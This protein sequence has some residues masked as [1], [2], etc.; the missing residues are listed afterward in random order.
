MLIP[1]SGKP[2][3][4]DRVIVR[5]DGSVVIGHRVVT[6]FAATKRANA[7]SAKEVVTQEISGKAA[8]MFLTSYAGP[9]AMTRVRGA[10]ATGLFSLS[11]ALGHRCQGPHPKIPVQIVL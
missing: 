1:V 3:R 10:H 8:G 4:D 2:A 11:Q 6:D 7:P 9:E 5:P